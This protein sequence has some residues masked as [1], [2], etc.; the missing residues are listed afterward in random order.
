M[1]A[2]YFIASYDVTDPDGYEKDYVPAVEDAIAVVGGEVVVATGSARPLEGRAASQ[3]VVFRFPSEESIRS[4]Y[5]G[6]ASAPVHELRR[7]TTTNATSVLAK[8][9]SR[10]GTEH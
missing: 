5:E 7:M 1:G 9:F 6:A 8:G 10:A 4:W 2:T 3:T